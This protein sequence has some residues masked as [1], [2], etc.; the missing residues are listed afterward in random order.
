MRT[1]RGLGGGL[2][3]STAG[4]D[5]RPVL[6]SLRALD[7]PDYEV[8]VVDDG[9]TD[10]TA[11]IAGR[12]SVRLV[13]T[14]NRGL[15]SARNTGLE[16]ATGDIV[17]YL[18]SD[19]Y[20]DPHWL[21]YLVRSF[22]TSAH[23]GV[24]GP[25]CRPT[26]TDLRECVAAAGRTRA[27]AAHRRRGGT[28]SR[29]QHG[30]PGRGA[31][32]KRISTALRCRGRRRRRVLAAPGRRAGRL[33]SARPPWS[34]TTGATPSWRTG[35]N[36]RVRTA[37]RPS[38]KENSP[39]PYNTAGHVTWGGRLY[40]RGFTLPLR[41]DGTLYHGTWAPPVPVALPASRTGHAGFAAAHA[42]VVPADCGVGRVDLL[43]V[44]WRPVSSRSRCWSPRIGAVI[45]QAVRS[46][47][48]AIRE[49]ATKAT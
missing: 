9:S 36:R 5:A 2:L 12:Y 44:L 24:G 37:P 25:T 22:T 32:R 42:R 17:A 15:S 29:L 45:V 6:A 30:L 43:G 3:V 8:I 21:K 49:F 14:E 4:R 1:C 27:R 46:A 38:W 41:R 48:E 35:D 7:Y 26:T 13:S 18:D 20:P 23:V 11:A 33:V 39:D 34:G 10:D 28:H 16:R 40:G 31:A 47:G 19:A